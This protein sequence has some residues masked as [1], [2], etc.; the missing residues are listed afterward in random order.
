MSESKKETVGT[1]PDPG[2][3][4]SDWLSTWDK[5]RC[6]AKRQ[7]GHEGFCQSPAGY[8]TDHLGEGRCYMH[9]GRPERTHEA[10]PYLADAIKDLTVRDAEA[11]MSMGTT[12]VV[13]ARARLLEKL[14]VIDGLTTKEISDLTMSIQRLDNVL[15]KHPDIDDPDAITSTKVDG[16]DDEL[17]RLIALERK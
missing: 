11:L 5:A 3:R 15:S 2:M 8:G 14:L 7:R 6:N 4:G 13:L 10:A 12:A 16:L 9:G 1:E 17:K